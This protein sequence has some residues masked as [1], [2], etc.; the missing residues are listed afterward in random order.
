MN[1]TVALDELDSFA[2]TFWQAVGDARVFAFHGE[3]GAGKTTLISALCR[4]KGVQDHMGSPTFSII[5]EYADGQGNPIYHMDLYRLRNP[6]EAVQTGVEDTL[7]SGDICLAEWPEQAPQLFDEN[8]LH[9]YL[10]ANE[11]GTRSIR[12]SEG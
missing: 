8:A 12:I 4:A 5:N 6:E 7:A 3:M 10:T 9:V 1:Y 11:D 2:H